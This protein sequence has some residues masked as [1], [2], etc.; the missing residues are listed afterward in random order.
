MASKA[1]VFRTPSLIPIE[2]F[3]MVGVNAKPSTTNPIGFF[4]TGLKYA[5]AVL[6]RLGCKVTVFIGLVEYEFYTVKEDFRGKDF[7]FVYMK[8]RKGHFW[9]RPVKLPFTL[10]YGKTW[11]VW[12]AY[13]ELHSNTLDEN[14]EIYECAIGDPGN[15]FVI[16]DDQTVMVVEGEVFLQA[17]YD[18]YKTFLQDGLRVRS[19]TDR[20]QV[21]DK[22]SSHLYYRGMR[23]YDL[24][25]EK[26]SRFTW[27]FLGHVDLTEDRTAK[28]VFDLERQ[29][30][31]HVAQS[32]DKSFIQ[33]IARVT[34]EHWESKMD[35]RYAHAA[36]SQS[37]RSVARMPYARSTPLYSYYQSHTPEPTIKPPF[38]LDAIIRALIKAEEAE[39]LE[40]RR[41]I[42]EGIIECAKNYLNNA[43][44]DNHMKLIPEDEV[45]F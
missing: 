24:P 22:P 38:T 12:Q 39:G 33:E 34:S 27:N 30:A 36:P 7:D 25:K 6:L 2:A 32:E 44:A 21:I 14:G 29:I 16:S 15:P 8:K 31:E 37:F 41:I 42:P 40:F 26:Q 28:Y 13:R 9:S 23:I 10:E 20:I 1:V 19:S 11:E 18:R 5:I 45:P 35:F 3:T 43:Y 4:G 17:Y